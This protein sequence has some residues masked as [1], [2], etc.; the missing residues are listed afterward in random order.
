MQ[1]DRVSAMVMTHDRLGPWVAESQVTGR[2]SGDLLTAARRHIE[3][4]GAHSF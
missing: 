1:P 2:R 3:A 4:L